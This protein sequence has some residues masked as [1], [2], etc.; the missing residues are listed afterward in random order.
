DEFQ[1]SDA[2]PSSAD[3]FS[4]YSGLALV[5]AEMS[6]FDE[7]KNMAL[8][9]REKSGDNTVGWAECFNE[10]GY[11]FYKAGKI[12]D[13]EYFWK[14]CLNFAVIIEQSDKTYA[15]KFKAEV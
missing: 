7:A 4:L 5:H 12:K 2:Q 13:A 6:S 3:T 10:L 15:M 9:G 14:E 8:V 1:A 11:Y